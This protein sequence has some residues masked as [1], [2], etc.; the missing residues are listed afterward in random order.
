MARQL[1]LSWSAGVSIYQ[2]WSKEGRAVSFC[3]WFQAVA[4]TNWSLTGWVCKKTPKKPA[5]CQII[6]ISQSQ[7]AQMKLVFA[8]ED[9]AYLIFWWYSCMKTRLPNVILQLNCHNEAIPSVSVGFWLDSTSLMWISVHADSKNSAISAYISINHHL[10]TSQ[11]IWLYW[12]CKPV[13]PV[14]LRG[15]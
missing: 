14:G 13:A 3:N 15:R 12:N 6:A 11:P 4:V 7:F 1:Q 10:I 9:S 8:I 5:D 2:K